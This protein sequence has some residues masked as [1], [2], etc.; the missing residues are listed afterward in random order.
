MSDPRSIQLLDNEEFLAD[1][2]DANVK[3]KAI[4][5]KWGVSR[6]TVNKWRRRI[7]EGDA[8]TSE[9]GDQLRDDFDRDEKGNLKYRVD[10]DRILPLSW[11]LGRLRAD[12]F[13]PD[14]FTFSHGHSVW[15]QHTKAQITKTLYANRFSATLRAKKESGDP[16]WPVVQAGPKI[17]ARPPRARSFSIGGQWQ[18]AILSAD[19]QIGY[20]RLEDG[21]LDPFHDEAAIDVFLKVVELERPQQVVLMGDI[22]DLA[23]QGRW[24]QE[25]TF[26]QT[27]QAAID[28]TTMLGA[29]LRE[30][31]PGKLVY[32]EGNHDRRMQGFVEANALA[33]FGLKK[34]GLPE[35]WPVMS[36]PNLLRLDDFDIEYRDAYPTAHWWVNDQLR[37]E[38]GTKVRSSGSTA[39][40]YAN[41]TPHI[42]RAFG[43]THRLEAQSKTTYDRMG[44]IRSVAINPGCLCRVD[45]GVPG[46]NSAAGID[47]RPAEF[48]ENWQQGVAVI[49]FKETGEF[50]WELLQVEDGRTIF[51]GQ[52]LRAA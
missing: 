2:R 6:A 39:E 11:W 49:R 21:T 16:E 30:R 13:D 25:A 26:A 36:L 34:G 50:F 15:T 42:S 7:L 43:H 24:A 27:T 41:E 32:I 37:C 17:A 5:E 12:G 4:A 20:R 8:A 9:D 51:S 14:D 38:H 23:S 52:E 1:L 22:I 31:T 45:G 3:Q 28:R 46:V 19:S 29:E 48:F 33:A 44:K 47:G 40:K 18:T 10:A 35:S